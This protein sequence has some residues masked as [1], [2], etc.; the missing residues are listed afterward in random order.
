MAGSL[1]SAARQLTECKLICP[2]QPKLRAIS[3]AQ[4]QRVS[5][6]DPVEVLIAVKDAD[7]KLE[8][9]ST[10]DAINLMWRE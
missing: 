2:H 8:D 4:V 9:D 6:L 10:S 3:D 5:Q 7:E 1:K